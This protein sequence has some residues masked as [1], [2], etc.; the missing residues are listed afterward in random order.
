MEEIEGGGEVPLRARRKTLAD[1]PVAAA[2]GKE[3]GSRRAAIELVAKGQ[4]GLR[5]EG[6]GRER[7]GGRGRDLPHGSGFAPRPGGV[8][9]DDGVLVTDS[10]GVFDI[11]LI[12]GFSPDARFPR[13]RPGQPRP[14]AVV[15][16]AGIADAQDEDLQRDLR[17][18]VRPSAPISSTVRGIAPSAWVAQLRQGS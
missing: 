17:P 4:D 5:G 12:A 14:Q 16:A 11:E 3:P 1:I 15:A 18:I 2:D 9:E 7:D 6:V 8:H 13:G 10:Q